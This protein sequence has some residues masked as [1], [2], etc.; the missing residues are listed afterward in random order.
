MNFLPQIKM[1][2]KR[3]EISMNREPGTAQVYV[4][5]HAYGRTLWDTI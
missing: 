1:K 5:V 2:G 4:H 3:R